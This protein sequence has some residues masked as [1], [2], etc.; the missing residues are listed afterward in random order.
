MYIIKVSN[1]VA[2]H[3]Y[4]GSG[5]YWMDEY[6]DLHGPLLTELRAVEHYAW[7]WKKHLDILHRMETLQ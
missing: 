1:A 3:W 6:S 4:E 7:H 2:D 5:W